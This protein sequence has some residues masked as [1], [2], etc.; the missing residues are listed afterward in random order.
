ME[1][2]RRWSGRLVARRCSATDFAPIAAVEATIGQLARNPKGY[3]LMVEWDMYTSDPQKGL[4]H[5]IEMDDMIRRVS[6]IAGEDTLIVFTADHSFGLRMGGGDRDTPLANNLP[7]QPR[8]QV[9]RS[10]P[11]R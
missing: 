1:R 8:N 3:F 5:V 2:I 4:R 6:E 10:P 9:Q 11:T 7:P